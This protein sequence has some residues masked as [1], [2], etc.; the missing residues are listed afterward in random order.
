MKLPRRVPWA[1]IAE[2]DE[3]CAAIYADESS[4]DSKTF[5]INRLTAWKAITALPH[6]VDS[7]L[8]ILAVIVQDDCSNTSGLV[9]RQ[10]YSAAIIRMVNGLVDPLQFGV[11]ARSIA[12]IAAQL[13]LPAWLVELRHAATHEDLPSL[14]VLRRAA[15]QSMTWLLHNY[16]LP[17]LDPSSAPQAEVTPLRP[18]EPI[19]KEYKNIFKLVTRDTSLSKHYK[20]A[21]ANVFKDVE[22]WIA[23]ATVAANVVNGEMGWEQADGQ[24]SRR[25]AREK[26][27]L[28]MFS[29]A[30]I[31]KGGL[32]PLSKKKRVLSENSFTPPD[33]S[34]KIWSPLLTNVQ[35]LHS[36]FSSVLLSRAI[37]RL[38]AMSTNVSESSTSSDPSYDATL[39]RWIFW[40]VDKMG[41]DEGSEE[42]IR[43]DVVSSILTVLAPG[44]Q[45]PAHTETN[46]DNLLSALCAGYPTVK[47][48]CTALRS[49]KLISSLVWNPEDIS[50]M[51]DRLDAL[52]SLPTEDDQEMHVIEEIGPLSSAGWKLL[53]S[54]CWK[55]CP[56]GVSCVPV[57]Q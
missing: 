20:Q 30:L 16:W 46:L 17:T 3:V 57:S 35:A 8:S 34:L 36:E 47:S 1:S 32:I 45:P 53:D 5:A 56:I 43:I 33:A 18:L 6:A 44:S 54:S 21:T 14:E 51:K 22:K 48:A 9:L 55:P 29:D 2:L 42:D 4:L 38:K 39:A 49:P 19:L 37:F 52:I 31:D 11:Y 24:E 7:T 28:E 41:V 27:A 50:V 12:A 15:Q 26:W 10:S 23:E 13:G 25:S 40:L